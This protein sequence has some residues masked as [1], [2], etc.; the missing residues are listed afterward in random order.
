M[1]VATHPAAGSTP[2]TEA[3]RTEFLGE[4]TA[5]NLQRCK[6][7]AIAGSMIVL[8][9]SVLSLLLPELHFADL[10]GWLFTCLGIYAALLAIRLRV[11][12]PGTSQAVRRAYVFAF[13]VVLIAICDGF[14]FVLSQQ[15]TSVSS[16][17][18]GM[19]VTAV[20]F[21]LPP[22]RFIPFIAVN[23]ILLCVWL[24]WRGLDAATVT[25]FLDGT[26]GAVVASL[27]SWIL[28]AAKRTEF[29]QRLLIRRQHAEM[30]ELM[31]ITA[32]DLRSPLLG[33][34]N[35]LALATARSELDRPRLFQVI[36]DAARGCDRLLGLV[37][38]LLHAHAAEQ[39]AAL[40]PARGDLRAALAAAAERARPLAQAKG[41][42]LVTHLADGVAPAQFDETALAQVLD[43]LLGNA[44]KF[45][46]PESQVD[47]SLACENGAWLI[48]ISD[49]G[50]GV[51]EPE[52][53]RLFQK[54]ARGSAL[55]TGG[56]TTTG[57]GL[58][59]VKTLAEQMGARV[60]YVPCTPAGST[61]RLE[62]AVSPAA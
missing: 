3:E 50:P 9:T 37:G 25:A 5:L 33:I 20:L 18:R 57:L 24:A 12:R 38:H 55:P 43:N 8:W 6:F 52:R 2:W 58:Y 59:I 48:A 1:A 21:V 62:L 53:S 28:Y 45:S 22:R 17:S 60:S 10:R 36:S 54:Y 41:L 51:P 30:N 4:V 40:H 27:G 31:A 35:L 61:F 15:L 56:E 29:H 11:M 46:P 19:L 16:F 23:E 49:E 7:A 42:R 13:V 47:V 44:L 39:P 32:H 14:F 26:A 34:K